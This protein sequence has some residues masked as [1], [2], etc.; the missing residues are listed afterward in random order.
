MGFFLILGRANQNGAVGVDYLALAYKLQRLSGG[1]F[2]SSHTV[3]GHCVH[4]VFQAPGD[5]GLRA[6]REHQ[7]RGMGDDV[8]PLQG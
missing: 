7:V 2:F 6:M 4:P 3:G 1:A 8:R 5:H